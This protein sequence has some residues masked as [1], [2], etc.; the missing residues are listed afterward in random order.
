MEEIYADES[1][2]LETEK[3]QKFVR[4][5]GNQELHVTVCAVSKMVDVDKLPEIAGYGDYFVEPN[6]KWLEN[7]TNERAWVEVYYN[8]YG[9]VKSVSETAGQ[10]QTVNI[11]VPF[12]GESYGE[13]WGEIQFC[14]KKQ[15]VRNG[16]TINLKDV[17]LGRHAC[18]DTRVGKWVEETKPIELK[19][20]AGTHGYISLRLYH[21]DYLPE[22]QPDWKFE[23]VYAIIVGKD[24]Y[25]I[26]AIW[27]NEEI[28]IVATLL[29][30]NS[31]EIPKFLRR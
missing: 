18:F 21:Q 22:N 27:E 31:S 10:F 23:P 16:N 19:K 8:L 25:R 26:D 3:R 14:V 7:P 28:K 12:L 20:D 29:G 2:V 17:K 24:S 1:D 30:D 15:I 6:A 4:V 9:K 13:C 11:P 5:Y